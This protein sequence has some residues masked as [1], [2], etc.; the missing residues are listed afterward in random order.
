MEITQKL[1]DFRIDQSV[2]LFETLGQGAAHQMN[3]FVAVTAVGAN[4]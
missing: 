3:K 1:T 2:R 4:S